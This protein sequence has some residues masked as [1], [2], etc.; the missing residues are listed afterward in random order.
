MTFY[1]GCTTAWFSNTSHYHTKLYSKF[2]HQLVPI[3]SFHTHQTNRGMDVSKERNV[4]VNLL[5]LSPLC[6]VLSDLCM[7]TSNTHT[8]TILHPASPQTVQ[9]STTLRSTSD[10]LD[11]HIYSWF[12]CR[13]GRSVNT[14]WQDRQISP[15]ERILHAFGSAQKH[16]GTNDAAFQRG[17]CF[18]SID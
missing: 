14:G 1:C 5:T 12:L 18:C 10:N 9:W 17:P 13:E 3:S 6:S 2:T 7:Q 15:S 4:P 16:K 8:H 11:K